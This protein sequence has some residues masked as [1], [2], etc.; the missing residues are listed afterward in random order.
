LPAEA[1]EQILPVLVQAVVVQADIAHLLAILL[2]I[3]L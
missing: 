3:L 1:L 2:S